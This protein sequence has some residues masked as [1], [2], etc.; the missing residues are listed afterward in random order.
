MHANIKF[1]KPCRW[2]STQYLNFFG[3][4]NDPSSYSINFFFH[5]M[6]ISRF[7]IMPPSYVLCLPMPGVIFLGKKNLSPG[8][9]HTQTKDSFS[10]NYI[11]NLWCV[12]KG[13]KDDQNKCKIF[14]FWAKSKCHTDPHYVIHY[15]GKS[16]CVVET[17]QSATKILFKT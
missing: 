12:L 16:V 7:S 9:Y 3:I 15:F 17:Y 14:S 4:N 6:V 8:F 2:T 1:S 5:E 11:I 10:C 13:C